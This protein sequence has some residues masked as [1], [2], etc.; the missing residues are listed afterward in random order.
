MTKKPRKPRTVSVDA[1]WYGDPVLDAA[2]EAQSQALA[3][4]A[5]I[6]SETP[7]ELGRRPLPD[8]D[9]IIIEM[10]WHFSGK[11]SWGK[12]DRAPFI[13]KMQGWCAQGSLRV[14]SESWLRSRYSAVRKR[15]GNL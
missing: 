15:F 12:L 4:M 6:S 5:G 14:P 10:C 1:G 13:K 7:A 2:A 9:Q 8:S 11:G 3:K